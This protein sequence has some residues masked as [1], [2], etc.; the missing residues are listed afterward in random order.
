ML[1]SLLCCNGR[2]SSDYTDYDSSSPDEKTSIKG[3]LGGP[4]GPAGPP[5][6]GNR[7]VRMGQDPHGPPDSPEK[8]P[9]SNL[10]QSIRS[11]LGG[12]S[13][14]EGAGAMGGGGGP[15]AGGGGVVVQHVSCR[16]RHDSNSSSNSDSEPRGPGVKTQQHPKSN[17]TAVD[18]RETAGGDQHR[19]GRTKRGSGGNTV[20][21]RSGEWD[22]RRSS[23][24]SDA[25]GSVISQKEKPRRNGGEGDSEGQARGRRSELPV[26]AKDNPQRKESWAGKGPGRQSIV[27]EE[28]ERPASACSFTSS[29]WGETTPTE[30]SPGFSAPP[31]SQDNKKE[32]MGST[33]GQSSGYMSTSRKSLEVLDYTPSNSHSH[34]HSPQHNHHDSPSPSKSKTSPSKLPVRR[35]DSRD[36]AHKEDSPAKTP[37]RPSLPTTQ[38]SPSGNK[39]NKQGHVRRQSSGLSETLSSCS[40]KTASPAT[41]MRLLDLASSRALDRDGVD[42]VQ[43]WS[44]GSED[45]MSLGMSCSGLPVSADT[46]VFQKMQPKRH[47]GCGEDQGRYDGGGGAARSGHGPEPGKAENIIT[48]DT[49][50]TTS[51]FAADPSGF[52]RPECPLSQIATS[53]SSGDTQIAV[54]L[55]S[56]QSHPDSSADLQKPASITKTR[57]EVWGKLKVLQ[58][59]CTTTATRVDQEDDKSRKDD[60]NAPKQSEK[61][62]TGHLEERKSQPRTV[63]EEDPEPRKEQELEESPQQMTIKC[64]AAKKRKA[65]ATLPDTLDVILE[66]STELDTTGCTTSRRGE[67]ERKTSG[68]MTQQ[69][70]DHLPVTQKAA[71]CTQGEGSTK[72]GCFQKRSRVQQNIAATV[73][74]THTRDQDKDRGS[75]KLNQHHNQL[76]GSDH[77]D[78][79]QGSPLRG[80]G[81][82]MR[83]QGSPRRGQGSPRRGGQPV[84]TG[85][86]LQRSNLSIPSVTATSHSGGSNDERSVHE[87]D[88]D[89]IDELFAQYRSR[90]QLGVSRS[91]IGDSRESLASVYSDAGEYNYGSIPVSGEITFGLEFDPK[92][93]ALR[94]HLKG[95]RDLAPVNVKRNYSDPYVKVYLLPDKTR[96][97][98]QKSKIKKHTLNPVF[99][100]TLTYTISQGELENRT[101]WLTVWHNDRLGRNDFLGEVTIPMDTYRFDDPSPCTYSL[102][103]RTP[104]TVN[105]EAMQYRG[106]LVLSLKYVTPN[107]VKKSKSKSKK[108]KAAQGELGEIHAMIKSAC[109]LTAARSNGMSD[110]FVKGYLLPDQGKT[111]KQ[112]TPVVKNSVNPTWSHILIFDGV[113]AMEIAERCLELTVWDHERLGTNQFLGGARLNLGL[114]S[115]KGA[116]VEWMDARGQ[117]SMVWQTMMEHPNSWLDVRVPLR[118]SMGSDSTHK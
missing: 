108:S 88:D 42:S 55:L 60:Q 83:G 14:D 45:T 68:N 66:S 110:P 2:I 70:Q 48:V 96:S 57:K 89:D 82:P 38:A 115:A 65:S 116:Q 51:D 78:T 103:P 32:E 9:L 112:K 86:T 31:A 95:C 98:K 8:T 69:D 40:A 76:D 63:P 23:V 19:G 102:L 85:S 3:N 15:G 13:E 90:S 94:I 12:G 26:R 34:S 81:S 104:D 52:Q 56:A 84:T 71:S 61:N 118:A 74:V 87:D 28:K 27:E 62:K 33:P 18:V 37:N 54:S 75:P 21:R 20:D 101:L 77:S 43:S 53:K 50:S 44:G 106:E 41:K 1:S 35:Q 117:E 113:D 114:G 46:P 16:R 29:E 111:S 25:D 24:P 100:E 107:N 58:S 109:N 4:D 10:F 36:S 97:G 80:Q 59:S 39:T 11:G 17:G 72:P 91:T 7:A 92:L 93:S 22:S 67:E 73:T 30:S 105:E 47:K 99:N 49:V 5:S 64:P 6:G 79:G